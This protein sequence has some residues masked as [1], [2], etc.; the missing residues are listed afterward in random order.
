MGAPAEATQDEEPPVPSPNR[1]Q[2]EPAQEPPAAEDAPAAH[3]T[4]GGVT[5]SSAAALYIN[6]QYKEALAEYQLLGRAHP[7]QHVYV[8]LARILR[9]KLIETCMRTQPHRREQC[10]TL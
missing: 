2:Q 5:A 4:P 6:G 8:E 3:T 9:R 7:K 10:K 1:K